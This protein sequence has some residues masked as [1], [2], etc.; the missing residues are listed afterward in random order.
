MC[1]TAKGRV[2]PIPFDTPVVTYADILSNFNLVWDA[3][4]STEL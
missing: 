1:K 2:T 3:K 4:Q